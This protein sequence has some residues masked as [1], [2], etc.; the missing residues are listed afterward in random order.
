MYSSEDNPFP[1]CSIRLK[2]AILEL[3]NHVTWYFSPL[4]LFLHFFLLCKIG[5]DV[6]T[7]Y[8]EGWDW[9]APIR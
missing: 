7:Q 4:F 2:P 5:K 8:V 6:A 9:I 3:L 1:N